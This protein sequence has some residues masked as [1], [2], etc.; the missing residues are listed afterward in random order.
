MFWGVNKTANMG[1]I[2][3]NSKKFKA[4]IKSDFFKM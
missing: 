2:F 3:Q 4:D 1:R